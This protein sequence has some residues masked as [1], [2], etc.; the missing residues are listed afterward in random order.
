MRKSYRSLLALGV[1]SAG[2]IQVASAD[3]ITGK[4]TDASGEAPLQGAI[5]TIE[6]L[7]RTAASDRFGTY[8]FNNIPAG[9]Y[10][11]SVSYIRRRCRDVGRVARRHRDGG[12]HGW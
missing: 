11:L 9:D 1:A 2:L 6:E 3:V 5:V 8:R 12:L 4:V 7:G 10:T